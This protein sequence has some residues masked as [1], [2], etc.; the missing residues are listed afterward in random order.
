MEYLLTKTGNKALVS[1]FRGFH[2]EKLGYDI[3]GQ[4]DLRLPE[5]S[6]IKI[7][8]HCI[9]IIITTMTLSSS[10]LHNKHLKYVFPSTI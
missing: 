9:N 1:G 2:P 7:E 3:A 4:L 5:S 6:H 8:G 10:N